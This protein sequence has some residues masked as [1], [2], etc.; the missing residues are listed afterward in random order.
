MILTYFSLLIPAFSLLYSPHALPLMLRPVQ[1]A[2]LPRHSMNTPYLH[3]LL[4]NHLA[5]LRAAK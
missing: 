3:F 1:D 2:P 4:E 5:S